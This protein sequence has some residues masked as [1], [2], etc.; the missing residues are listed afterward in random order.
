MIKLAIV[1]EQRRSKREQTGGRD[2]TGRARQGSAGGGW[3]QMPQLENGTTELG[4]E[5]VK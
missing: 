2:G 4:A 5:G 3:G 1:A